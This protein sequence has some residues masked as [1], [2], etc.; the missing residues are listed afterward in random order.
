MRVH[1]RLGGRQ[2]V[3]PA[4][5]VFD[6]DLRIDPI[7]PLHAQT[8]FAELAV[9]Q[10]VRAVA[11]V[12]QIDYERSM[13]SGL[14]RLHAI[15][16]RIVRSRLGRSRARVVSCR[17]FDRKRLPIFF[18]KQYPRTARYARIQPK[19]IG[20]A[21]GGRRRR[22]KSSNIFSGRRGKHGS[23][24]SSAKFIG[25]TGMDFRCGDAYLARFGLRIMNPPL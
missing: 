8:F 25:R 16:P 9:E 5:E 1:P 3:E 20:R 10:L 14:H 11:T 24:A 23:R 18:A 19:F 2:I 12:A 13:F 4:P 6:Q 17:R 21:D 7:E 15:G 22:R